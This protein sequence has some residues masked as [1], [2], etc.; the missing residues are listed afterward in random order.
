MLVPTVLNPQ[1]NTRSIT[2]QDA[3]KFTVDDG[4]AFPVNF[5]FDS[6]ASHDFLNN[7]AVPF[8]AANSAADIAVAVSKAVNSAFK[9]YG[10]SRL[11]G[12]INDVATSITVRDATEFPI[13]T[14]FMPFDI[15][16]DGEVMTV[17]S[18]TG[19]VLTVS[20]PAPPTAIAHRKN[21]LVELNGVVA[22]LGVSRLVGALG[23]TPTS[24]SLTVADVT[25]F[26]TTVPFQ[27]QI[28]S[29]VMTVT[30]I[31]G[32]VF[33]VTRPA[34]K[35][36]TSGTLVVLRETATPDG[37]RLNAALT[38]GAVTVTV[39]DAAQFPGSSAL[40]FNIRI[41][42]ETLTVTGIMGNVFNV[43]RTAGVAHPDGVLVAGP[44][45]IV[46][47]N[48]ISILD[49]SKS[50]ALISSPNVV[51]IVGNQGFDQNINGL[52]D[53]K[54]YLLGL[55]A[56]NNALADGVGM[57]V[58][59]GVTAMIDGG[60]LFKLQ[61]ANLD[62]GTS[63]LGLNRQGAAI[64]VLGTPQTQVHFDSYRNDLV[65]GDS[66][67]VGAP[68]LA[69]DYGGIVFRADSDLE[70]DRIFLNLVNHANIVGGGGKVSVNTNEVVFAPVHMENSRPTVSFNSITAGASA[71]ISANPNS[72]DDRGG[73]LGPDIVGNY[74]SANSVNGLFVRIET[75]FDVPLEKLDV[76]ARFNDTDITHV[77]TENLL[78]N[79]NPGGPTGNEGGNLTSRLS[80]RLHI[81]PGVVVKLSNSRIELERGSS[82][83]IAEGNEQREVIFT[84]TNDDRF[85]GSGVFDTTKNGSVAPGPGDWG[86][87]IFNHV[88]SG[89][90][91]D[92][93]IAFGGG[94][95]PIEGTSTKFNVIEVH[96]AR[97]R[98]AN[99]VLEDNDNGFDPSDFATPSDIRNGRG[100]NEAATIF[101]RGAQ[102]IIINNTIRDNLGVVISINDNSLSSKQI[103]DYGRATG[104]VDANIGLNDNVG[105]MVRL[106]RLENNELNGMEVRAS[107]E[108][109][110]EGVWDDVDIVHILR[111]VI[112]IDNL[113]TYGG[114][115]LQSSKSESLV[116]KLSGGVNAGF[117]ATGT[118][119]EIDDRIGGTLHVLGSVGHPVVMTS[120]AD[121]TVGAGF[122]PSGLPLLD[123]NND[124]N[125]TTANPGDWR[126][127]V[128]DQF[129]NDR[130]VS[131]VI[132]DEKILTDEVDVN[133]TT[134]K[135]Q[136]LGT[137]ARDE[138]SGSE[139]TRLGFEVHGSIALDDPTDIDVYSFTGV[140]GTDVWLD[141]DR[142]TSNTDFVLELI[143]QSGTV[144]Q[145]SLGQH[146]GMGDLSGIGAYPI[147]ENTL[148]GGDVYTLNQRDPGLRVTLPGTFGQPG[149][150]FVRVRSN[151]GLNAITNLEGGVTSGVYKLQIRLRQIDEFA[152]S[153]VRL[154]DIRYP[155]IGI[156]IQ[157]LP[158]HSPLVSDI[159]E[160]GSATVDL[161][162]LLESDRAAI[163]VSGELGSNTEEQRFIFDAF[164]ATNTVHPA[165]AQ[166]TA[167]V[168]DIDYAQ[169][170]TRPDTTVS[171]FNNQNRLL[172]IGRESNVEDDQ[173]RP[174]ISPDTTE[175][176]RGSFGSVD[177]FIGPVHLP[178]S[179][180]N[181]ESVV[182]SNRKIPLSIDSY[183]EQYPTDTF[184]RLEPIPSIIRVVEDH[185]AT[186]A[187]R[188]ANVSSQQGY[189]SGA[190][191]VLPYD[192]DGIFNLSDSKSL[193]FH[194]K[195]YTMDDVRLFVSQTDTTNSKNSTLY[196]VN[197]YQGGY[198]ARVGTTATDLQDIPG[199][200]PG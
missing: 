72:F 80:G 33:S 164:N 20:R 85:G 98:L 125:A 74:L 22:P 187:Q 57:F 60:A 179:A 171:V 32:S 15:R 181:Y 2:I 190:N 41:E 99:S 129:S 24:N 145:R 200:G 158:A 10:A 112:V 56:S 195:K 93:F 96:Q 100:R 177:P 66:N 5:E 88:S 44:R 151:T 159:G 186:P 193:D 163:N 170:L 26:P 58:P 169:G 132:E 53:N 113:H 12:G 114:L 9:G 50:K 185:L 105:P 141:I 11:V 89:S 82:N 136:N 43:T 21:A 7:I 81:D 124:A 67:G 126:G 79:G 48:D 39:A 199:G 174:G 183:L 122:T 152:G 18:R 4:V 120:L 156:D 198:S 115:R 92:S 167:V 6:T 76:T 23:S 13:T 149:D 90:I 84:S 45:G 143:N 83:L 128:F 30:G 130:N 155:R 109:T 14:P 34:R 68:P 150:Y 188:A 197:P 35:A 8:N 36:H 121:D 194:I 173:Q 144:L 1:T 162:N 25:V 168:F 133:S 49:M 52:A 138:K 86:G 119:L 104:L 27:V 63:S 108:L 153:T 160:V 46:T 73:R 103:A 17:T 101:V 196:T 139:N 94:D 175:L 157:G 127:L 62:A 71:A 137:L 77:I 16:I 64:Q 134:G 107:S 135:A 28:D 97:L 54:P 180:Q 116:V 61:K 51:R 184:T 42:D 78:I 102:P 178:G 75:L 95:V 189:T 91:D 70:D 117:T 165:N 192:T 111:G 59:Q 69:G 161:G 148:L 142:T 47:F 37:S 147:S 191:S 87:L 110:T 55:D 176:Q 106:N 131:I 154:A 31:A 123:T 3:D 182:T 172:Y 118:P 146:L 38:A 19:N 166:T 40:P 29:E 65:G 140:A